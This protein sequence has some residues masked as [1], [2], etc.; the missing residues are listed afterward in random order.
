[1]APRNH[2]PRSKDNVLALRRHS[3]GTYNHRES[4]SIAPLPCGSTQ[5]PQQAHSGD[6]C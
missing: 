4:E 3:V 1:M 6:N 5:R 2:D